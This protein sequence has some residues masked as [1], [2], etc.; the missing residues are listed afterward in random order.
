[1]PFDAAGIVHLT[2]ELLRAGLDEATI[3]LVMGENVLR[4]LGGALPEA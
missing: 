1:V 4:L 2:D 3:R